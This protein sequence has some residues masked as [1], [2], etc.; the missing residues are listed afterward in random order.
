MRYLLDGRQMKEMDAAVIHE[1]GVPSAVLMERAALAAVEVL[2]KQFDLGHVLVVCGSGN[3]GGD[4][5]AIAR[6]L[7]LKNKKVTVLFAGKETSCTQETA[8]QKKICEKYQIPVCRNWEDGEYTSIVDALF[9]IGLSRKVEG[10]YR[11]LIEQINAHPAKVLAV[12]IA[13]GICADNGKVMGVAVKA[14]A[15]VTFAYEKIGHVLYPGAWYSGQVFT[16]DIGIVP[17]KTTCCLSDCYTYDQ[18][19]LS[20]L[21]RRSDYSNKGTYG[22][23]LLIAGSKNMSGAAYLSGLAAYRVGTGLV[24][25]VTES[26]NHSILQQL[27]PEAILSAEE[28]ENLDEKK[29][30][31]KL[32]WATAAVVGPGLGISEE[33]RKL[34]CEVIRKARTPLVV[35]ADA[36]NLLSGQMEVLTEKG[37]DVILT[38]HIME[39]ARISRRSKEEIL[40]DLIGAAK[41]L[42]SRYDVICVLKDA[43]TIVTDGK[44]VYINKSGNHG[45]AVGGSGDVLSGIIAGLLAQKMEPFEAAKL[46][47]YLHGMAG[48]RA[49]EEIGAAAM[50]ASDLLNQIGKVEKTEECTRK[51]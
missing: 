27:L 48:D 5:F 24:Q 9:G 30:A 25:I 28:W 39:M 29:I 34:V 31:E 2:E 15:T 1:I 43:R 47:V 7:H 22:K 40:E 38:P 18:S 49:R 35:D 21:P 33:K 32:G 44:E 13:S 12:D 11:E 8:L 23:T 6:L 3:N 46:G 50:I 42:A 37:S 51:Q 14:D 45:M 10:S 41:A 17:E 26:C 36:L 16:K 19:D 20:R 4:G